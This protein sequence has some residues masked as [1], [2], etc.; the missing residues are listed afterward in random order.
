MHRSKKSEVQ[1]FLCRGIQDEAISCV[2]ITVD[3]GVHVVVDVDDFYREARFT[4]RDQQI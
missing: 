4:A 3:M 1:A 2:A